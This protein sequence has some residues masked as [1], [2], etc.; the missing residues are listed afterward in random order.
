MRRQTHP[1]TSPA[2][3]RAK[4]KDSYCTRPQKGR[5]IAKQQSAKN[6]ARKPTSRHSC[7]NKKSKTEIPSFPRRR[8]SRVVG[9]ET[10]REKRFL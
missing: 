9:A 4:R 2:Q 10:Y 7:K 8:E 6:A 5:I 3:S 1:S